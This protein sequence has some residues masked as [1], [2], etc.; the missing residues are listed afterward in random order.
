[1]FEG[2]KTSLFWTGLGLLGASVAYFSIV[3]WNMTTSPLTLSTLQRGDEITFAFPFLAGA[4]IFMVISL[5]MMQHGTKDEMVRNH[6]RRY[7]V[8]LVTLGVASIYLLV[9]LWI[10]LVYYRLYTFEYWSNQLPFILGPIAFVAAGSYGMKTGIR[11]RNLE[12]TSNIL[13]E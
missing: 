7:W 12:P 4:T 3:V 10:G 1:M 11:N 2:K 6:A 13:S 5:F 9:T 8:G